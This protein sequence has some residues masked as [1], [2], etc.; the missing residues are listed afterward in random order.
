MIF[1][2]QTLAFYSLQVLVNQQEA[3]IQM[4]MKVQIVSAKFCLSFSLICQSHLGL[5]VV[6]SF[7]IKE[8]H[9][10]VVSQTVLIRDIKFQIVTEWTRREV[11]GLRCSI[12]LESL[13]TQGNNFQTEHI[14]FKGK[15]IL[16]TQIPSFLFKFVPFYLLR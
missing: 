13:E 2:F 6:R 10:L 8:T 1:F 12:L 11:S 14:F 7:L 15:C 4:M 16:F 5:K 3:D 9:F